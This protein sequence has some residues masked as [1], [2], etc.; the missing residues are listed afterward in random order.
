MSHFL[1]LAPEFPPE[2]GGV[3]TYSWELA[4]ELQRR[5]HSLEVLTR[6]TNAPLPDPAPFP[7]RRELRLRRRHDGP[8]VRDH[9]RQLLLSTAS[10]QQVGGDE[11]GLPPVVV[12]A[13]N[14]AYAALA[15]D[16]EQVGV[17]LWVCIHGN[18]FVRPYYELGNPDLMRRLGLKFGSRIDFHLGMRCTD[19]LL[20][21]TFPQVQRIFANSSYSAARFKAKHPTAASTVRVTGM[22]L[23]PD[24]LNVAAGADAK[25]PHQPTSAAQAAPHQVRLLTVCRLVEHT[26]NVAAVIDALSMLH[27]ESQDLASAPVGPADGGPNDTRGSSSGTTCPALP[28]WH[29]DII[30]DGLLR[31][32]LGLMAAALGIAE[33][34]TFHGRVD[35]ATLAAAY[36]RADLFVMAPFEVESSFEGFGIVYLEANAY[37]LPVLASKVGGI[38]DAVKE[39]RSG[40]F[41][42]SPLAIDIGDE[43]RAF[44]RGDRQIDGADCK[45][46]A[47]EHTWQAVIDRMLE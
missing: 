17:P 38:P 3:Q 30:G 25:N 16:L 21:R 40:W 15:P 27:Q 42:D 11:D 35:D 19:R 14:A 22:G 33:K 12:L 7:V 2:L 36:R 45:A 46:H 34:V 5:G 39:F 8:L 4:C 23:A 44:L 28:D 47:L 13:T 43:L 31:G 41:V 24:F 37:G 20:R 9:A 26:K 29:Y 1:I 18:D 6:E 10:S 32:D